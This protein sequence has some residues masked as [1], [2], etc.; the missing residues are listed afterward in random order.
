VDSATSAELHELHARVCKAIADPERL[1][2]VN[3]MRAGSKS[4]GDLGQPRQRYR[5]RGLSR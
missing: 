3:E 4:L 2:P 1:L 5:R